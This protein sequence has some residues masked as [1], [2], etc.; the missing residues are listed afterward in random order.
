MTNKKSR[1]SSSIFHPFE[2][3]APP[4]SDLVGL[5]KM[6]GV[7][8]ALFSPM[9]RLISPSKKHVPLPEEAP[10]VAAAPPAAVLV[11]YATGNFTDPELSSLWLLK[12]ERMLVRR[13]ILTAFYGGL[14]RLLLLILR[15]FRVRGADPEIAPVVKFVVAPFIISILA[16]RYLAAT[17]KH[18]RFSMYLFDL[19]SLV[20]CPQAA[21]GR[22]PAPLFAAPHSSRSLP[23]AALHFLLF[24]APHSSRSRPGAALHSLV[25]APHSSRS[26]PAPSRVPPGGSR[27]PSSKPTT[28]PQARPW[29]ARRSSS[30]A[31]SRSSSRTPPTTASR[32]EG[33]R[34]S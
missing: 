12:P 23:G 10:A 20:S 21:V 28:G 27:P 18:K 25:P 4:C 8:K 22:C 16:Y 2:K 24:A 1:K 7:A 33:T 9:K 5:I 11:D 29:H 31:V 15:Q 26:L 14:L 32:L 34:P 19:M 17:E 13:G 3:G 6:A 30:A